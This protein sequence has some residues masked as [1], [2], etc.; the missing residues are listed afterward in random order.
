MA[1]LRNI[2]AQAFNKHL[3]V[4]NTLTSGLFMGVG[5]LIVQNLSKVY[6]SV[7]E[8]NLQYTSKYMTMTNYCLSETLMGLKISR[9]IQTWN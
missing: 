2:V 1:F 5:D 9:Q 7:D 4:T 6:G 3:L 8:V